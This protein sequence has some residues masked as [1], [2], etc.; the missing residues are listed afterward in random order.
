MH[1]P[2][3]IPRYSYYNFNNLINSFS[4]KKKEIKIAEFELGSV[5]YSDM[6]RLFYSVYL[7][8]PIN[9]DKLSKTRS[10]DY[11]KK[12]SPKT[13]NYIHHL[14][15]FVAAE[16]HNAPITK[17]LT[18]LA[19][20]N[21]DLLNQN[22]WNYLEIDNHW[23]N[24]IEQELLKN[25]IKIYKSTKVSNLGIKNNRI[26]SFNA[27]YKK[28][29]L[30]FLDEVVMA[31]DPQ[32]IINLL[33]KSHQKIKN[34]W[35]DFN[36][37]KQKLIMSSY[38]SIGITVITKDYNQKNNIWLIKN[39][40]FLNLTMYHTK[41]GIYYAS[42]CDLKK[43][44]NGIKIEHI[45]PIQLKKIIQK[46]INKSFPQIVIKDIKFHEDARFDGQKWQCSHTACA[47]DA[48]VGLLEAKG[49]IDNLQF[50]NSLTKG[51]TYVITTLETCTEA[52]ID[53]INSVS[54]KK[55]KHIKYDYN[56][57]SKKIKLLSIGVIIPLIIII[58]VYY[59]QKYIR[60]LNTKKN[61]IKS[62]FQ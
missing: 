13:R 23:I 9:Y 44:I 25:N 29:N 45:N 10:K 30:N 24:G 5:S 55:V 4:F 34:N 52:A 14:N 62:Y 20:N 56:S 17:L 3:M 49:Q 33:E 39:P 6:L 40:T 32:G 57:P 51:R 7:D 35:G 28:I 61:I 27:N 42:I 18:V 8:F 19:E 11:L 54:I 26:V 43:T 16:T 58:I 12:F 59:L 46:D 60:K 1:S 41:N 36:I 15:T 38:K 50:R 53:Y 48:H 37:F 2:R 21:F 31:M 47:Q 22:K